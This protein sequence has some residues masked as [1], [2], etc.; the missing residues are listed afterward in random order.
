MDLSVKLKGSLM[1]VVALALVAYS[2]MN[3]SRRTVLVQEDRGNDGTSWVG[4]E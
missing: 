4:Q 1:D 3:K 2:S